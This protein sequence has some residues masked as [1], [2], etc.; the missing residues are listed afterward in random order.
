MIA[1]LGVFAGLGV[2]VDF[3]LTLSLW[4]SIIILY[5]RHTSRAAASDAAV[6]T[7]QMQPSAMHALMR[8]SIGA[9]YAREV[10]IGAC[11]RSCKPVAWAALVGSAPPRVSFCARQ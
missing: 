2:M 8:A 6:A 5:E 4:P 3:A 10:R 1:G 11:S 7:G 9:G